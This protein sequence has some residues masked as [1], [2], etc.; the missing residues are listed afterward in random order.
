MADEIAVV[1]NKAH[2]DPEGLLERGW[3]AG[4]PVLPLLD[5]LRA[6]LTPAAGECLHRFA[7]TQDIVDTATMLQLKQATTVLLDVAETAAKALRRAVNRY[8]D[9]PQM[10]RSFLQPAEATTFD[11]RGGQWLASLA[12]AITEV[13]ELPFPVQFGG[14]IG[15]RLGLPDTVVSTVATSLGLHDA[16]LAWH[17]DRSPIACLVHGFDRLIRWSAKVAGDLVILAQTG[18]ATM[19]A[20]GS[21]AMP[22]KRNPIDAVRA[23][24]AATAGAGLIAGMTTA[25]PHELERAAGSWHAEWFTLPL[26]AQTTA[27]ALDAVG[28][29]LSS[30]VVNSGAG[31][32]SITDERRE[33]AATIA[34]LARDR[35]DT[36][37]AAIHTRPA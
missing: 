4:T 14:A 35:I 30:L 8:G 13:V 22:H 11:L 20:G 21:T 19:R 26:V 29:A 24:A 3:V 37:L 25:K 6:Q 33:A 31:V 7:T 27:A 12:D 17:T 18:E 16:A 28:V 34:I 15:D 10:A 23:V 32:G 2:A 36:A 1:C 9:V 5:D